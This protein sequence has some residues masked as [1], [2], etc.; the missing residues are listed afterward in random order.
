MSTTE[1]AWSFT[2]W[3]RDP[4]TVENTP[5]LVERHD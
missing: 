5:S 4:F 3:S 2:W 1:A